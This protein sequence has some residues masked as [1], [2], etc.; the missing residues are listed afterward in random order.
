MCIYMDPS[1]VP[2]LDAV[3]AYDE[4][5]FIICKDKKTQIFFYSKNN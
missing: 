2:N 5:S 1:A 4:T 3:Q